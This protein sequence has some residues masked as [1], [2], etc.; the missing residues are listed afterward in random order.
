MDP[1]KNE[2][3]FMANLEEWGNLTDEQRSSILTGGFET[4]EADNLEKLEGEDVHAAA[5]PDNS[6]AA[7]AD[8][9]E[10]DEVGEGQG[11]PEGVLAKDG[12][13]I[14]PFAELEN[15]RTERDK[16]KADLEALRGQ[17]T[18]NQAAMTELQA[19]L[20]AAKQ[21]DQDAGGGTEEQEKILEDFKEDYPHIAEAT[22]A[23][24][25]GK[26]KT[27]EGRIN[28]L[29]EQLNNDIK[30]LRERSERNANDEH[31]NAIREAHSDYAQIASSGKLA[32]WI[33][34]QPSFLQG[35]FFEITKTGSTAEV[36]ELFDAY[37]KDN[38]TA[39]VSGDFDAA[40][41]KAKADAAAKAA[42]ARGEGKPPVSLSDAAGGKPHSD[43]GERL[44][45]MNGGQLLS[46][47]EG[48]TPDEIEAIMSRIV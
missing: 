42:T 5:L 19:N 10:G 21:A 38:P 13:N 28:A 15:T 3:Y 31:A 12:K 35:R 37:K 16:F 9:G 25:N 40:T 26:M 4:L 11:E 30:P 46:Q 14:I 7:D 32:E 36:I 1:V 43:E 39:D 48:K 22:E 41:D 6:D 33:Q 23:L 44:R 20:E 2:E 27:L 29:S 47:F 8:G 24:F 18:E 34:A 45:S 17:F